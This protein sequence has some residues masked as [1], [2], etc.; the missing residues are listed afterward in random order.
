MNYEI[1]WELPHKCDFCNQ[2][3]SYSKFYYYSFFTMH[4]GNRF[5]CNEHLKKFK[6]MNKKEQRLV[7]KN[8]I[9]LD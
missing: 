6:K 9:T 5:F 1:G 2:T 8:E 4:I 7:L 3:A